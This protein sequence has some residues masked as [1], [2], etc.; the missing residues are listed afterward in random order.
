[1]SRYVGS[2][3]IVR[4]SVLRYLAPILMRETPPRRSG[5]AQSDEPRRVVLLGQPEGKDA[6]APFAGAT[7]CRIWNPLSKLASIL[8]V[9]ATS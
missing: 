8:V 5:R 1:M 6:N 2:G 4:L 7:S 3:A 9:N